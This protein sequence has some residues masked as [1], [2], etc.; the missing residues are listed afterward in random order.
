M[1]TIQ[2]HMTGH[3]YYKSAYET[4]DD[5]GNCNGGKCD[6]CHDNWTVG[7]KQFTNHEDA[8]NYA[9]EYAIEV[10]ELVD[11]EDAD[12][13]TEFFLNKDG[14]LV[15]ELWDRDSKTTFV[16]GYKIFT[17]N[18]KADSY[19]KKYDEAS[20]ARDNWNNCPCTDK[21][22]DGTQN[23]CSKIGCND[24]Q[25]HYEVQNKGRVERKWYM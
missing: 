5:C 22:D 12:E 6:Y 2:K 16:G 15:C 10:T 21:D 25:C 19:K 8:K 3:L 13:N 17:C 11:H 4:D 9:D 24:S 18:K 1:I 20:L 7:Q 23:P 14:V